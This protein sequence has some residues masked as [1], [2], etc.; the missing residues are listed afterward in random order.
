MNNNDARR[1]A[2]A[3]INI[4]ALCGIRYF[5]V[6]LHKLERQAIRRCPK[7][8]FIDFITNTH[9]KLSTIIPCSMATTKKTIDEERKRHKIRDPTAS[10][11]LARFSEANMKNESFRIES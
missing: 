11:S 9:K 6:S 7:V 5:L 10:L 8:W 1:N 2:N 4:Q 3:S